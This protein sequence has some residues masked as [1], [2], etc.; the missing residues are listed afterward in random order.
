MAKLTPP[1]RRATRRAARPP[2][3]VL[4]EL[5][6]HKLIRE[7]SYEK[8]RDK[9]RDV[10]DGPQGAMLAACSLLSLHTPLGDRLFRE[11]QF[12]LAGAEHILD[13]GS[14]AGQIARHVLKYADAEAELTCSDLSHEMLS[15][16]G[17]DS[18]ARVPVT[19]CPT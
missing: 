15:P 4:N 7:V 16:A 14:G 17:S 8:Y 12:D 11:R 19:S 9:V 2:G 6:E 5:L 10:Y 18:R 3:K 13:V 1:H